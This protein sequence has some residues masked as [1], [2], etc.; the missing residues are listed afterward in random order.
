M[1]GWR[2]FV[3][4]LILAFGTSCAPGETAPVIEVGESPVPGASPVIIY[5]TPTPQPPAISTIQLIT[6]EIIPSET[7]APP[8]QDVQAQQEQCRLELEHLYTQASD[9]CLGEANGYVCNGGL[10]PNARP[11][12]PISNTMSVVGSLVEA[13]MVEMIHTAPIPSNHSGGVAWVRLPEP[14]NISMLLVGNVQVENVTPEDASL[15]PWQSI[16]VHTSES[17][18]DCVAAPH[19]TLVVQGPYG[20]IGNIV[21]NGVSTEINGT[22]AIQ[23]YDNITEFIV[24]EGRA[25]LIVYGSGTVIFA[26]QHISIPYPQGELLRPLELP[27][28]PEPLIFEH[29]YNLPTVLLDRPVLLPQPGV[30]Y[31]E[32]N[33]N[34]RSE[35]SIESRLLFRVPDGQPLSVLGENPEKTWYHIRLGNGETGWMRKDLVTGNIGELDAA[36][37]ATPLPPQRLGDAAQS[38]VVVAPSGGNLRRAPDVQFAVLNTLE[39]GTEVTLIARSPYSP[40]V[41][42]D[43]GSQVGWMALITIETQS[44]IGFLPVDYDVPPPPGPT[45]TPIFT[46]GGGHAYPDPRSGQ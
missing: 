36:Y 28:S 24:L 38:A 6:P 35:P 8:T 43:T 18:T 14:L 10:P 21:I 34:M 46:F 4:F 3:F 40:W 7:L 26:G 20:G 37:G 30:A 16:L 31:T 42:V 1:H 15:A 22:I 41:K 33:V 19:D 45:A 9:A 11:I 23:T 27:E 32:G 12:G 13:A 25:R 5:V 2:S 29:I 44:V 39:E 17:I